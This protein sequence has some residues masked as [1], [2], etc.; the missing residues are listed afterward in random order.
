M[1]VLSDKNARALY[2]GRRIIRGR[3]CYDWATL[4]HLQVAA[5]AA[6]QLLEDGDRNGDIFFQCRHEIQLGEDEALRRL[7]SDDGGGARLVVQQRQFAE[8]AGWP[9]RIY[10]DRGAVVSLADDFGATFR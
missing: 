5:E 9:Q 10:N 1:I 6:G 7:G 8:E 2:M 3:V 4:H